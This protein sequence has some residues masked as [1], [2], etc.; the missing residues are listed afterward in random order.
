M[1][2][3]LESYQLVETE[4]KASGRN[5]ITREPIQQK[6]KRKEEKKKEQE[7]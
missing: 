4:E 2:L 7:I 5:R 1:F 3:D 6:R